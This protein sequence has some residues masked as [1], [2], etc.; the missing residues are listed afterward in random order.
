[1]QLGRFGSRHGDLDLDE[2]FGD[3]LGSVVPK[4]V[5][6]RNRIARGQQGAPAISPYFDR[7]RPHQRMKGCSTV[8]PP[9][10]RTRC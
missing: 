3:T 10:V 1:M 6:T 7:D 9:F 5:S 8:E 2:S 4:I